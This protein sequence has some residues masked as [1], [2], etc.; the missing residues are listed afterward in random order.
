VTATGDPGRVPLRP[1]PQ[2]DAIVGAR[3]RRTIAAGGA[4]A[5]DAVSAPSLVRSGDE[6]TTLVRVGPVLAQGRATALEDG[7][8]GSI[9]RVQVEKR[10]LRGRV[11]AAGAVEITP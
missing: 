7:A 6:V 11:S 9:V 10:R 3:V 1:L 2:A 5:A 4:I 8:F